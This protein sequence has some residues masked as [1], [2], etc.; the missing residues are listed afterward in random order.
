[1]IGLNT[2]YRPGPGNIQSIRRPHFH[3]TGFR[4]KNM[5]ELGVHT[6]SVYIP[7]K[8]FIGDSVT[9][10][11]LDHPNIS[12]SLRKQFAIREPNFLLNRLL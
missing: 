3:I 2:S 5:V 7:A 8:I 1:M 12:D 10:D 9:Y 4:T 11:S 6:E